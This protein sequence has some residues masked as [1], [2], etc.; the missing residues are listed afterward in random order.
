VRR[1]TPEDLVSRPVLGGLH[2]EYYARAA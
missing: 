2:H 1:V